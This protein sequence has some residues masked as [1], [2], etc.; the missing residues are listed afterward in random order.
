MPRKLEAGLH[1]MYLMSSDLI[2]STMKSEP[3]APLSRFI[4]GTAPTSAA[5]MRALGATADGSRCGAIGSGAVAAVAVTGAAVAA[6]P[7]TAAPDRN[8]RRSTLGCFD[9]VRRAMKNLPHARR[10]PV[11]PKNSADDS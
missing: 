8:L 3:A 5:A 9:W 10:L 1:G 4:S 6:A 7:A 11:A 2:T